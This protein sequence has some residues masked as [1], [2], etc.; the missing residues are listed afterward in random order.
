[1][2]NINIIDTFIIKSYTEQ[3][4]NTSLFYKIVFLFILLTSFNQVIFGQISLN[5]VGSNNKSILAIK[6]NTRTKIKFKKNEYI[7]KAKGK[8]SIL[9][10]TQVM[11]DSNIIHID[12]IYKMGK[13]P[14]V[15][16]YFGHGAAVQGA[17]LTGIGS[18]FMYKFFTFDQNPGPGAAFKAILYAMAG[19]TLI[20]IGPPLTF[21]GEYIAHGSM[22]K[23]KKK[24]RKLL[25]Q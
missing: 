14:F 3:S 24:N 12:S 23:T 17:T 20:T 1:M 10:D 16:R 15:K 9:N 25:I 11:V 4:K 22:R 7:I 6:D 19:T 13:I 5:L 8:I 18:Y 2:L 21:A